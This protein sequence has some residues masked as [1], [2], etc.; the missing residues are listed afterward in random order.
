MAEER[1]GL[2]LQRDSSRQRSTKFY[3]SQDDHQHRPRIRPEEEWHGS[4]H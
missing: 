3:N 4:K 2:E 1:S